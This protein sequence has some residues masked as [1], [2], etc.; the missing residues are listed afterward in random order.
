MARIPSGRG[1]AL[2]QARAGSLETDVQ[3][4][5]NRTTWRPSREAPPQGFV[6]KRGKRQFT[7]L[8]AVGEHDG[9]LLLVDTKSY[10]ITLELNSG[11]GPEVQESRR[12]IEEDSVK[13]QGKTRELALN[14]PPFN[15]DF[16]RYRE[17]VGVVV[18]PHALFVT[19]PEVLQF[20]IVSPTGVGL[21]AASTVGELSRFLASY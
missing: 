15:Y 14:D 3:E 1:T 6:P 19:D 21:R 10:P 12:R 2:V 5:I 13:W 11:V 18:T 9:T 8:D 7:D 17:V 20:V 16:S 4:L